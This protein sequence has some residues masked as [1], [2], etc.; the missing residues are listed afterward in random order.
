M[1]NFPA[2]PLAD[3]FP[4]MPEAERK[5]LADD[6]VTFGQRDPIILLDGMV[7]DGRNRQWACGFAE[8]EPIYEQYSGDDPLNFVL[9]KNLH[10]RHLTESQRALIV[11]RLVD[12]RRGDNQSTIRPENFPVW[13]AAQKL[14]VSERSVKTAQQVLRCAISEIL[15]AVS[16]GRIRLHRAARIAKMDSSEQKRVL[17]TIFDGKEEAK[18]KD[19]RLQSGFRIKP[20]I[21]SDLTKRAEALERDARLLRVISGYVANADSGSSV[22]DVLTDKQI[23]MIISSLSEVA[24]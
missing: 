24:Q 9:S 21:W 5:L 19:F 13:K 1:S 20:L 10:R 8:I 6:I 17:R 4:M 7:L 15:S 2:H 3:L 23:E 22:G 18:S 12:V 14:S 11:A 16:S